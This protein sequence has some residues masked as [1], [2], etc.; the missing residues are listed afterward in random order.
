VH[1]SRDTN[2]FQNLRWAQI[3]INSI[4]IAENDAMH[5]DRAK[6]V[7]LNTSIAMMIAA[8]TVASFRYDAVMMARKVRPRSEKR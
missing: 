5:M 3:Y 8:A 2:Y 4:T 6:S 7:S 1:E